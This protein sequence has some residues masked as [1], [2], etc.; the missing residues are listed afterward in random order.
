VKITGKNSLFSIF[1]ADFGESVIKINR[2]RFLNGLKNRWQVTHLFF[3]RK[4]DRQFVLCS[5]GGSDQ[6]SEKKD[7]SYEETIAAHW[8]NIPF[9]RESGL[10]S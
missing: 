4:K 8:R 6:K 3:K 10:R 1:T 5:A 9:P 7:I 2:V